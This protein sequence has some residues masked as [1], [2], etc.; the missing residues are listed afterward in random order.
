[1]LRI[2]SN[3]L[4]RLRPMRMLI[5]DI[6]VTTRV[7]E[8]NLLR[9]TMRKR[10]VL[11]DSFMVERGVQ[12]ARITG[13]PG[14]SIRGLRTPRYTNQQLKW[15]PIMW[16]VVLIL[17]NKTQ[18]WNQVKDPITSAS[19]ASLALVVLAALPA[20]PATQNPATT[21]QIVCKIWQV[22][23]KTCKWPKI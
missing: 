21:N 8:K 23:T 17:T 5:P 13:K 15:W 16:E 12:L 18:P 14:L 2:K 6:K 3:I 19:L 4:R 1:M 22:W 10:V 11:L 20:Y 7:K 9:E